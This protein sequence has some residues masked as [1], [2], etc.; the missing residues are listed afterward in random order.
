MGAAIYALVL[1]L[2]AP[3]PHK[4]LTPRPVEV[5]ALGNDLLVVQSSF[6]IDEILVNDLTDRYDYFVTYR[7]DRRQA[8]LLIRSDRDLLRVQITTGLWDAGLRSRHEFVVPNPTL[9][10]EAL[11]AR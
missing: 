6:R 3:S 9:Q 11:S 8:V 10:R 4:A 2:A 1:C 5:R 7:P